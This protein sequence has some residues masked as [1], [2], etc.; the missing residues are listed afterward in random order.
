MSRHSQILE[1]A[2]GRKHLIAATLAFR[3]SGLKLKEIFSG[4]R[5]VLHQ[6]A[7]QAL[8]AFRCDARLW[9][10]EGVTHCRL[11]S[12]PPTLKIVIR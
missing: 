11:R 4:H 7:L 2:D 3:G 1:Q 8:G 6:S 9:V 10:S 12:K 5:V